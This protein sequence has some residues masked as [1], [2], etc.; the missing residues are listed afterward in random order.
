MASWTGSWHREEKIQSSARLQECSVKTQSQSTCPKHVHSKTIKEVID[1]FEGK[2]KAL[3]IGA[4][5]DNAS[6]ISNCFDSSKDD[7]L[8]KVYGK[9]I[10]RV[11]CQAHTANLVV[12]TYA[13]SNP[14]FSRLQSKIRGYTWSL[15]NDNT[16][17]LFNISTRWFNQ[18]TN[19][20]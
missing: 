14:Y 15:H 10:I 12:V 17:L 7:S 11:S 3:F 2:A 5:T 1:E 19:N 4:C 9:F 8:Q 13:R 6:N 16:H 18:S 20:H